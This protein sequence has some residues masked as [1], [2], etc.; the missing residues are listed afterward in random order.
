[1]ARQLDSIGVG[2]QPP[3]GVQSTE[4]PPHFQAPA[5]GGVQRVNV[6]F[7]EQA[8]RTLQDLAAASGKSMSEI[9]REAIALKAW[10][11]RERSDGGKILVERS[12]GQ[13]REVISV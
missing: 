12:N 1:V 10:F 5:A 9:L 6:N 8:Y 3:P 13:V 7:S 2:N 4:L 11:E